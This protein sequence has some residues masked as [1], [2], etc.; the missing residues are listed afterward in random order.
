MKRTLMILPAM[1]GALSLAGGAWAGGSTCSWKSDGAAKQASAGSR[2]VGDASTQAR[3][4]RC[5][6]GANEA[7]LSFAVPGAEC[8]ACV[9]TIQRAVMAQ[10]GIA[11]AHVNLENHT[12]YI[13]ASKSVNQ[14]AIAKAI[15]DAGFRCTFKAEGPKVRSELMKAM[16]SG[17]GA[18]C[19]AKKDKDKV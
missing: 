3:G 13:V 16:A 1:L 10:K 17:G 15:K 9:K 4:E 11:C 2:C 8:E 19:C 6:I 7:V 18:A 5:T 12:A 14:R